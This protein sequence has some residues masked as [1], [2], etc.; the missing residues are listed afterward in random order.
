MDAWDGV[1]VGQETG[2]DPGSAV[3]L[4]RHVT[5]L[6]LSGQ[7]LTDSVP[8]LPSIPGA[9]V[10]LTH[11]H[12]ND[13][14]LSGSIPASLGDLATLQELH[15]HNNGFTGTIPS[16]LGNLRNLE[17]L[18]LSG[19]KLS[20]TIPSA[21]SVLRNLRTLHLDRNHLSGSVPVALCTPPGV[22]PQLCPQCGLARL[23]AVRSP[24]AAGRRQRR[25]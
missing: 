13:N 6:D 2:G 15:L 19:N 23:P 17:S 21:L 3:T 5:H 12:L 16:A 8:S 11:L 14:Y 25:G 22:G 18:R 7:Q 24:E 10:G 20:G 1:Q 4:A 9:M